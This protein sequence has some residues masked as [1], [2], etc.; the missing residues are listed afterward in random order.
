MALPILKH[1]HGITLKFNII[2]G[3]IVDLAWF[4]YT[5]YKLYL[6]KMGHITY[7]FVLSRKKYMTTKT[8]QPS[9][10]SIIGVWN[11]LT[12]TNKSQ[13]T[14]AVQNNNNHS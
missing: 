7:Q 1:R 3:A 10:V 5:N 4:T 14:N 13:A 2:H 6:A 8:M 12:L 9:D 11:L